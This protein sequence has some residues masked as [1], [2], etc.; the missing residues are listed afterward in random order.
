[1]KR[2]IPALI[3]VLAASCT[4]PGGPSESTRNFTLD[5][6]SGC[7]LKEGEIGL[8]C[9]FISAAG[10]RQAVAITESAAPFGKFFSETERAAMR[11]DPRG[12][13]TGVVKAW[14]VEAS[15]RDS[16]LPI[17]IRH[18]ETRAFAPPPGAEACLWSRADIIMVGKVA[19]EIRAVSCAL[20]DPAT[21]M[22]ERF[23]VQYMDYRKPGT[24]PDPTVATNAERGFRSLRFTPPG[25]PPADPRRSK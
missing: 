16:S 13:W 4:A 3:A 25:A 23:M 7:T 9:D 24:P 19:S 20:Y 12:F 18:P 15:E 6:P 1:M 10:G 8:G 14:E 22:V 2:T 11:K 21:D 5:L 17:E